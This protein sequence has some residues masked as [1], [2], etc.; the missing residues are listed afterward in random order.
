[1]YGPPPDSRAWQLG[2][3]LLPAARGHGYGAEVLRQVADYLFANTDANR[4]EGST[5]IENVASQRA[6]EKAR[7]TREGVNRAAQFRAGAYHDLVLYS[8]LRD[9]P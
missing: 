1:M 8:R 3:S 4:V 5:D 7:F 2:I 6:L 9:D